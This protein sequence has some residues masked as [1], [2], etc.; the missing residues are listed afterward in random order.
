MALEAVC[1]KPASGFYRE[2]QSRREAKAQERRRLRGPARR[3]RE[4]AWREGGALARLSRQE[5]EAQSPSQSTHGLFRA[6]KGSA[7]Y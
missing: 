5:K 1:P 4:G 6:S 7:Q 3:L 2:A